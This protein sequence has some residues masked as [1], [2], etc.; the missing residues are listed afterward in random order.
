MTA[1]GDAD[2]TTSLRQAQFRF[3]ADNGMPADGGYSA[4]WWRCEF[5]RIG[6]VLYNFRW[7]RQAIAHHDLHHILT[8]YACTPAGEIEMAAWE[9]AAGRYPHV[10]ATLFCLPLVLAGAIMLPGRTFA[11]HLRGRR[12]R[13]LYGT[14]IDDALLDCGVQELRRACITDSSGGPSLEDGLSF[15]ATVSAAAFVTLAPFLIAAWTIGMTL[16]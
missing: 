1:S 4:T 6:L 7:R 16:L 9:F 2:Q 3:F 8:G 14:P 10:A 5:G 11:A 12:S 13:T 15:C